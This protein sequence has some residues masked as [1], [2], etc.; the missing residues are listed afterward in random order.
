MRVQISPAPLPLRHL[1]P[2]QTSL[3]PR[4]F[5][6]V[7]SGMWSLNWAPVSP[8]GTSSSVPPCARAIAAFYSLAGKK[9]R[10]YRVS[11]IAE[12]KVYAG[13]LDLVIFNI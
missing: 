3:P 8:L 10:V 1:K 13:G 9:T 12:A 7:L 11:I 6:D 4:G 5:T 2:G